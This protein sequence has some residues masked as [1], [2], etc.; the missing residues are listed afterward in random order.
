ML[1]ISSTTKTQ[2]LEIKMTPSFFFFFAIKLFQQAE[3]FDSLRVTAGLCKRV[4]PKERKRA[5]LGR[6]DW[7]PRLSPTNS[8]DPPLKKTRDHT[9]WIHQ[10]GVSIRIAGGWC[11]LSIYDEHTRWLQ[12]SWPFPI[13]VAIGVHGHEQMSHKI[14]SQPTCRTTYNVL[15]R[16]FLKKMYRTVYSSSSI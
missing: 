2:I 6:F 15:V 5:S 16:F 10:V 12:S 8:D 13:A 3:H 1:I 4:C 7:P 9:L 14:N 11:V